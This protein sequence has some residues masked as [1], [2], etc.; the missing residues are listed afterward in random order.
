MSRRLA[1]QPVNRPGPL[2][3]PEA[4]TQLP[5]LTTTRNRSMPASPPI[6]THDSAGHA[7]APGPENKTRLPHGAPDVMLMSLLLVRHVSR[8]QLGEAGAARRTP[9][10]GKPLRPPQRSRSG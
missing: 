3:L 9:P 10:W 1:R 5:Q 2:V 8:L 6:I 7:A 4:A